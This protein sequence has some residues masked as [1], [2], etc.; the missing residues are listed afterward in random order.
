M[1]LLDVSWW[2]VIKATFSP[3]SLLGIAGET[4]LIIGFVVAFSV[5]FRGMKLRRPPTNGLLWEKK[6]HARNVFFLFQSVVFLFRILVL[7]Y[8]ALWPLVLLWV[9]ASQDDFDG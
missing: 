9:W 2:D 3:S 4:Y 5:A 8:I 7:I 1:L 6:D